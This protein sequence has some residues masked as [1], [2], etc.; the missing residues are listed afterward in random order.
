V[1]CEFFCVDV[2]LSDWIEYDVLVI[3]GNPDAVPDDFS[4]NANVGF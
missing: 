3:E 2:L 4:N 1:V